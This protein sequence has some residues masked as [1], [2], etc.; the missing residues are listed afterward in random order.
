MDFSWGLAMITGVVIAMLALSWKL[1]IV[2]IIVNLSA[3]SN[4]IR[5]IGTALAINFGGRE[6]IKKKGHYYHLY[7][8]QFIE[9]TS[10]MILDSNN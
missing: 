10:K 8:N 4:L 2:S 6:L 7:K 9:E 5:H 3:P 1:A